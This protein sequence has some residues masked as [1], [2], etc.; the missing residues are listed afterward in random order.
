MDEPRKAQQ[1]TLDGRLDVEP[2]PFLERDD[3]VRVPPRARSSV[4]SQDEPGD[5]EIERIDGEAEC[6]LP[7]E[8]E[9]LHSTGRQVIG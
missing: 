6:E 3:P 4:A 8:G 7:T 1:R 9:G 5:D 2:G